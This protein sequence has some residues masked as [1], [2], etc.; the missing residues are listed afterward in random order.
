MTS[1]MIFLDNINDKEW[2][3]F[4]VYSKEL[5]A[6]GIKVGVISGR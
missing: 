6:T 3:V 2:H 5:A 4:K 1:S